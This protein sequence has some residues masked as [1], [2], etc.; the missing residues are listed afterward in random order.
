MSF[1]ALVSRKRLDSDRMLPHTCVRA[2]VRDNITVTN[3]SIKWELFE[4]IAYV[5]LERERLWSPVPIAVAGIFGNGNN[6]DE[7]RA[8]RRRSP[9]R[10]PRTLRSRR[11][12][13]PIVPG[14]PESNTE[15]M[16][17]KLYVCYLLPSF[18]PEIL[19]VLFRI[20]VYLHA[21]TYLGAVIGTLA[22]EETTL[23]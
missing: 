13:C 4:Y 19:S 7:T 8:S 9:R 11:I 20:P 22:S 23:R 6:L 17:V 21:T 14:N 16:Y 15:S 12:A 2:C 18:A 5:Y 10:P 3:E 1:N